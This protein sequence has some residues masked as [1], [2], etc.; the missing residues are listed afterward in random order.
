MLFRSTVQL[1]WVGMNDKIVLARTFISAHVRTFVVVH[2]RHARLQIEQTGG[3]DVLEQC[4]RKGLTDANAL[5]KE[6]SRATFWLAHEIWPKMTDRIMAAVDATT[7]KQL[8]KAD[9]SKVAAA[10]AAKVARPSVRSMIAQAKAAPKS[11]DS[12]SSSPAP[13]SRQ[14]STTPRATPA[15]PPRGPAAPSS[16]PTPSRMPLR[17]IVPSATVPP[18][19]SVSPSTPVAAEPLPPLAGDEPLDLMHLSSPFLG[20]D[21]D[22]SLDFSKH[23]S[24]PET[25]L[26]ASLPRPR[27][28]SLVL[29]VT[30]P[31]VDAALRSQADQAEQAAQRLL[32]LAE[33]D[34]EDDAGD[35]GQVIGPG[36]HL[37]DRTAPERTVTPLQNFHRTPVTMRRH[38]VFEDSPDVRDPGYAG[39]GA[40]KG[41]WWMKKV[42]SESSLPF[43]PYYQL[44]QAVRAQLYPRPSPCSPTQQSARRRSPRSSRRSSRARSLPVACASSRC[45]PESDLC[46]TMTM[47]RPCSR[48]RPRRT[49][50]PSLARR[51]SGM[52][53][54]RS[55]ASSMGSRS[56][57]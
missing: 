39:N 1:L 18:D 36:G 56:S 13:M 43:L 45:S 15:S 9:P 29:P 27:N 5:V 33:S 8:D 21:G 23:V 11:T 47:G 49:D 3:L 6:N 25:P 41:N 19:A 40:A 26:L 50:R 16:P 46:V 28:A 14:S 7:K 22:S 12:A 17:K 57:C 20:D 32:E 48:V 54:A 42:D 38:D 51:P 52:A 10:P 31:I 44:P 30:E 2:G 37:V 24:G 4:V 34:A 55:V 53:H 35:R